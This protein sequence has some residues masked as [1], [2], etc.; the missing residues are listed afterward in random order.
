VNPGCS[1]T[2]G[3][4]GNWNHSA[5]RLGL[6]F[7]GRTIEVARCGNVA[8]IP[9][10]A[11]SPRTPVNFIEFAGTG[12]LRGS[13]GNKVDHGTVHFRGRAEDR[14]EPGTEDRY[15]LHVFANPADPE[16]TTLMLVDLDG[17]PATVDPI[18]VTGGNMQIHFSGCP[19]P[20]A[21]VGDW[22]DWED[23]SVVGDAD[24]PTELWMARGPN[25]AREQAV[26]SFGLPRPSAVALAIHD[27]SG[28]TVR[29][30]AGGPFAAGR[31]TAV[32]NLRD[33]EGRHVARGMYFL[34]LS[35]A[36]GVRRGSVLVLQ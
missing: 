31:H 33:D 1:P 15:F 24:L 3:Q 7:Q 27:V 14:G 10:G 20:S 16:G 32:W 25:P 8:G 29:T 35:T 17:D 18:T 2:S 23:Y 30:L 34:R 13:K 28:R 4:G 9:E 12:R 6:H 21:G 26:V 36:E 11:N 5:H 19:T 22:V